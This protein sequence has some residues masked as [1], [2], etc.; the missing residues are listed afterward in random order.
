MMNKD[1]PGHIFKAYDV[2]GIYP[3]EIDEDLAYK[4]GRAFVTF[5]LDEYK[6]KEKLKIVVSSDMRIS[7]PKLKESLMKGI[8]DQGSDVIDIGLA[9]SPTFYFAVAYYGYDGGV[10]VS[11]SHNPKEYNG[12]KFVRRNARAVSKETGIYL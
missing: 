9:S 11:A 12:F 4:T 6:P 3:S 2:R 5:L 1:F 8:I 10:I 7:S